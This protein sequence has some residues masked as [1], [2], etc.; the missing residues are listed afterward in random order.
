[1]D[2]KNKKLDTLQFDKRVMHRFVGNGKITNKELDAHLDSLVD[3]QENCEDISELVYE[4]FN[5]SEDQRQ[6]QN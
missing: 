6:E 1:M 5:E 4:H 2:K 3:L